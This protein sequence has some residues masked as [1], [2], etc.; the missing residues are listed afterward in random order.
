MKY[1]SEEIEKNTE[2]RN[3]YVEGIKTFLYKS[4]QETEKIRKFYI[5]PEKYAINTDKYRN[6]FIKQ[7]G[8]PLTLKREAP[9]LINKKFIVKDGNVNI[10]RMQFL[11][12]GCIKF[13]GLYFEQIIQ[14]EK[15]PFILG[16]HGGQG[17][18]ELIS[19]MH[20]NSANYNHII[21]RLT[22]KGANVFAPQLLLWGTETYGNDGLDRKITDGK[23]RQLGGSITALELYF[24]RGCVDWF[25]EKTDLRLDNIGVVGM[26][27]GGMYA[28]HLAAID[29]RIKV[30]YSCSWVNDIFQ[31]SWE[32]WSL[33]NAQKKFTTAEI[34]ALISPRALVV[35]MGD[36]D[37]LFDFKLTIKECEKV[38]EYYKKFNK[39]ENFKYFIFDGSHEIDKGDAELDFLFKN[40]NQQVKKV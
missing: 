19:S 14:N 3:D 24:L 28:A 9:E 33:L 31:N 29:T 35:A 8:F 6:D 39:E 10:Y 36:K 25:I 38:K 2:Y 18:P 34:L 7:L 27:Y 32:D 16:I 37:E 12:L 5:S 11:F 40:F 17:T 26:S 21:R 13:Y 22:D 23:L 1:Y 30:C 4:K 20:L 15:N